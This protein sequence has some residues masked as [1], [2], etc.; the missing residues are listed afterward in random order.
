VTEPWHRLPREVVKSHSLEIF[1][2]RL[3]EVLC[4][5]L[6]VTL[7]WQGV[8]LEDTQRSLPTLNVLGFCDSFTDILRLPSTLREHTAVAPQKHFH[9]SGR[10]CV[11]TRFTPRHPSCVLKASPRLCFS[12]RRVPATQLPSPVSPAAESPRQAA[13]VM[14]FTAHRHCAPATTQALL[15][16]GTAWEGVN[17]AC[18]GIQLPGSGMRGQESRETEP[19]EG[20]QQEIWI[21]L[22]PPPPSWLEQNTQTSTMCSVFLISATFL[23]GRGKELAQSKGI[24]RAPTCSEVLLLR[25]LPL[26]PGQGAGTHHPQGSIPSCPWPEGKGSQDQVNPPRLICRIIQL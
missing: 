9:G 18:H 14:L 21:Q 15:C 17:S 22:P 3:D 20:E 19:E 23:N 16:Y 4:S 8:G 5:L 6:W 2:P 24:L 12:A 7:L 10:H 1:K 11:P 25:S 26:L 13:A